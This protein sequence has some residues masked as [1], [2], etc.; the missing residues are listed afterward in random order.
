[1]LINLTP[2]VEEIEKTKNVYKKELNIDYVAQPE[3]LIENGIYRE[4]IDFNFSEDEIKEDIEYTGIYGVADNIEQIKKYL[5]K[6]I[7]VPD[8]KYII[9]VTPV[10]Q[11]KGEA[12]GWRWHKWGPYIGTLN[13]QCEYLD[14]EDFGDD[15]EYV[16]CFELYKVLQSWDIR[17]WKNTGKSCS[18]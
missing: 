3:L 7:D 11:H 12:D 9:A 17:Q 4:S 14:D 10:F 15:F 6:Y 5:K 2:D 18:Y 16:L 13:P 1:M 8:E